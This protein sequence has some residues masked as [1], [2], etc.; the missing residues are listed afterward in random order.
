M[1]GRQSERDQSQGPSRN[2]GSGNPG[3]VN[4]PGGQASILRVRVNHNISHNL[5]RDLIKG[6]ITPLCVY[7]IPDSVHLHD[8]VVTRDSRGEVAIDCKVTFEILGPLESSV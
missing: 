1:V 7:P 2:E 6:A 3:N 4:I 5:I 8:I